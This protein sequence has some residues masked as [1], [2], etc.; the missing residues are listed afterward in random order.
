MAPALRMVSSIPSML[1]T[2]TS[3]N[4][5]SRHMQTSDLNHFFLSFTMPE[6]L[7]EVPEDN[8]KELEGVRWSFCWWLTCLVDNATKP[9]AE[10][11]QIANRPY[12]YAAIS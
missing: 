9:L 10:L 7:I 12:V 11:D 1:K 3:A 4:T 5:N 2:L 8:F 6:R